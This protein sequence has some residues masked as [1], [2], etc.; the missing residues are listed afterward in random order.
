MLSPAAENEAFLNQVSR[1]AVSPSISGQRSR[2]VFLKL[3]RQN[4]EAF[5]MDQDPTPDQD[6][7]KLTNEQKKQLAQA[8]IVDNIGGPRRVPFVKRIEYKKSKYSSLKSNQ[9][10]KPPPLLG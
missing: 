4:A 10:G 3:C 7:L 1:L 2:G 5:P 6:G 9:P 8:V